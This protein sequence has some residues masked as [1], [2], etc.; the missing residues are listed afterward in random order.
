MNNVL[1]ANSMTYSRHYPFVEEVF[2]ALGRDVA[3]FVAF[4]R[5]VDAS[6]PRSEEILRH[7][8]LKTAESVDYLRAYEKS[9]VESARELLRARCLSV[10]DAPRKDL[11]T[12]TK[13]PGLSSVTW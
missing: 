8:G 9:V 1:L 7:A 11:T 12:C 13:P 5:E 6:R 3:R 4:F 10:Q 2:A